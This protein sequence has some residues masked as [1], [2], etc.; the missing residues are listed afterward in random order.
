M[1]WV[2]VQNMCQTICQYVVIVRKSVRRMCASLSEMGVGTNNEVLDSTIDMRIYTR[3]IF[4]AEINRI[5]QGQE[6][7]TSS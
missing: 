3:Q 2:I 6:L 1:V 5:G 7:A 4:Q